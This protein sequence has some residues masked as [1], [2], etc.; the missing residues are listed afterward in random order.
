VVTPAERIAFQPCAACGSRD[1][2]LIPPCEDSKLAELEELL[3]TLICHGGSP[4]LVQAWL[5]RESGPVMRRM[6]G[7]CRSDFAQGVLNEAVCCNLTARGPLPAGDCWFV[8]GPRGVRSTV[9]GQVG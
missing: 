4:G 7:T 2:D 8:V 3:R 6:R 5:E 9:A 1:V